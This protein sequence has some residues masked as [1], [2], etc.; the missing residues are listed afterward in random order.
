MATET[1]VEF[2]SGSASLKKG[3]A[4][5]DDE[6]GSMFKEEV[7]RDLRPSKRAI[8]RLFKK[9]RAPI[10]KREQSDEGSEN[11]GPLFDVESISPKEKSSLDCIS[12]KSIE[13]FMCSWEA[14]LK[15]SNRK[16]SIVRSALK[17]IIHFETL[18]VVVAWKVVCLLAKLVVFIIKWAV[19]GAL[20]VFTCA[21]LFIAG[22]FYLT[23]FLLNAILGLCLPAFL[24]KALKFILDTI[25]IV[26]AAPGIVTL[27]IFGRLFTGHWT[28]Q[29]D[30]DSN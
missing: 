17:T 24:S 29:Y 19:L 18:P 13:E 11:E 5:I 3:S 12:S 9:L 10:F 22:L 15:S 21:I 23:V 8:K 7:R 2:D 4:A 27:E 14:S 26:I 1:L 6:T 16:H 25:F 30:Y 28:V 20:S